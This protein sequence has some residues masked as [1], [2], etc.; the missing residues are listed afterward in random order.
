M[1][2]GNKNILSYQSDTTKTHTR[3]GRPRVPRTSL[4]TLSQLLCISSVLSKKEQE[5]WEVAGYFYL[6]SCPQEI[7]FP[8]FLLTGPFYIFWIQF[9]PDWA[10][11]ELGGRKWLTEWGSG[12]GTHM[13]RDVVSNENG[14]RCR[15]HLVPHATWNSS[16][17][18]EHIAC[19]GCWGPGYW[20]TLKTASNSNQSRA[21]FP[22]ACFPGKTIE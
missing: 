14:Q 21:E 22:L 1:G 13:Q 17:R 15:C 3:A 11:S 8:G 12:R 20:I 6:R 18:L 9:S 19:I 2:E 10:S 7:S 5:C 16:Q 4:P